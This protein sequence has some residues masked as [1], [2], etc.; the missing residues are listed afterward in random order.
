MEP[1]APPPPAESPAPYICV[2][3]LLDE[4]SAETAGYGLYSYLLL[5]QKPTRKNGGAA[6]ISSIVE[7][8]EW[9]ETRA[10]QD[11]P[12]EFDLLSIP[13]SQK[14]SDSTDDP[15]T[16]DW[17]GD[18]YDTLHAA[19]L[20]KRLKNTLQ[21]RANLTRGPY[22]L[23]SSKPLTL[24]TAADHPWMFVLDLTSVPVERLPQWVLFFK[25]AVAD[26]NLGT[27]G[28]AY[29]RERLLDELERTGES[30]SLV[31]ESVKESWFINLLKPTGASGDSKKKGGGQ[32]VSRN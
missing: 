28:P 2:W 16:A 13:V 1:P 19:S 18:H 26:G 17:I 30:I 25:R 5:N 20:L 9:G 22:I 29:Y 32:P 31:T 27:K 6:L 4:D 7:T 21:L 14:H 15:P 24:L 11:K 10:V 23:S 3:D 8:V 12:A